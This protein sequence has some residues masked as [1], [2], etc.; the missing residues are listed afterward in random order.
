MYMKLI[1]QSTLHML[2][3]SIMSPFFIYLV[4]TSI[5]FHY[6]T[7]HQPK[8]SCMTKYFLFL[9]MSWIDRSSR[10]CFEFGFEFLHY[11]SAFTLYSQIVLEVNVFGMTTVDCEPW[12][13]TKCDHSQTPWSTS[14]STT[15]DTEKPWYRGQPDARVRPHWKLLHQ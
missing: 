5:V 12:S 14:L 1:S 9:I 15:F 13:V 7:P 8:Y 2:T 6:S 4:F 3:L 11:L 10:T